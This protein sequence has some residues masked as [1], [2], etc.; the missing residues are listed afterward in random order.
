MLVDLA[1]GIGIP[2]I[3]MILRWVHPSNYSPSPLFFVVLR[4]SIRCHSSKSPLWYF[5]RCG[6]LAHHR[7]YRSSL[8]PCSD[9][10]AWSRR[11]RIDVFYVVCRWSS[12][13]LD[14]D[15][16]NFVYQSRQ[17]HTEPVCQVVVL[18]WDTSTVSNF[19]PFV[20]DHRIRYKR[21]R[22]TVAILEKN[23][24]QCVLGFH[25]FWC[26]SNDLCRENRFRTYWR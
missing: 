16:G 8:C 11:R 9:S 14:R 13:K 18:D 7:Q 20:C 3:V 4:F 2:V 17:G 24:L 21:S 10:T 12:T 1:I 6:L 22:R 25:F 19:N 5:W 15:Q 23:T 26:L